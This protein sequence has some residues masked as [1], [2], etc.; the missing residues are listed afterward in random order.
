[1]FL[2]SSIY[3]FYII[4]T[5]DI[6][7]LLFYFLAYP[8]YDFFSKLF[9]IFNC[10]LI[11]IIRILFGKLKEWVKE[12]IKKGGSIE[13]TQRSELPEV[14]EEGKIYFVEDAIL[15]YTTANG[16]QKIGGPGSPQKLEW[17]DF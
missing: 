8:E 4:N 17:H 6:L 15:Q 12:Q 9:E 3:I 16:Y 14:G 13:V 5:L 11:T 7:D 1:M 2:C 10:F